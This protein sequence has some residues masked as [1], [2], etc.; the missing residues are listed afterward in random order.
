M[1][2]DEP[3]APKTLGEMSLD[4]VIAHRT[5]FVDRLS[6]RGLCRAPIAI[7]SIRCARLRSMAATVRSCRARSTINYAK[8]LAYKDEYEVARLYSNG[9]FAEN[10]QKQF[11]GDYKD[12]LQSRAADPAQ[13]QR[14]AG[15]SEEARLRAWMLPVFGTMAK[16]RFHARHAVRSVQLQRGPQARTQSDQGATS[17]TW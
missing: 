8:L 7:W 12:Q 1:K 14:S 16:F 5:Q 17:R 15:P 11:E 13:W 6:E 4:E 2:G 10:L 3:E 9:K